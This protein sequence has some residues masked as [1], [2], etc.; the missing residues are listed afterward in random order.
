MYELGADIMSCQVSCTCK[1]AAATAKDNA[2]VKRAEAE[3]RRVGSD[4]DRP[5]LARRGSRDWTR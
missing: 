1:V 4:T 2:G 3:Q 5:A